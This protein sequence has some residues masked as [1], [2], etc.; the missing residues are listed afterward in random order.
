MNKDKAAGKYDQ[1]AGKV[2]QSVGEAVGN[3]HLANKGAAQQVKGHAK[4]AWGDVEDT[5]SDLAA[6]H[7]DDRDDAKARPTAPGHD[8]RQSVTSTAQNVKEKIQHGL[9]RLKDRR[10]S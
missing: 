10:A 7:N 5:A 8:V 1:V 3:N 6:Q 2:K 9:D 4:E